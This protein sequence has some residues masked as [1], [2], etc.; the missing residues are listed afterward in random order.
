MRRVIFTALLMLATMGASA[1]YTRQGNTFVAQATAKAKSEPRKTNYTYKDTDGKTYPIYVGPKGGCYIIR[2][3]K[4]GKEYP[5]YLG[6]EIS[7]QICKELGIEYKP[8]TK[9]E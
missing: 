5:K 4:N 2:T 1:Q 3:S 7:T 8:K 9:G 6:A